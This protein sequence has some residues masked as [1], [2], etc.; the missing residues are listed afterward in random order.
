LVH[1]NESVVN[2]HKRLYAVDRS[3][4]GQWAKRVKASGSADSELRD[5]VR[6]G[7]P[8]FWDC[9]GVILVDVMPR[10]V[11]INSEAYI[12]KLEKRFRLVWPGKNPAEMLLQHDN[13]HPHTGL[14]TREHITKMGWTMLPHP[15]YSPDLAP[16]DFHVFGSLRDALR[17]THF[18]D[19]NSVIEAMSG[20]GKEYMR[21]FHAV[22]RP[23][24][25]IYLF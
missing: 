24:K 15:P 19:D 4:V 8:A 7:C 10:G 1:E 17:G 13:A 12:N 2:I 20:T 5:L 22:V 16:S 9:D 23:Y 14:R 3:S 11:T 18:E 21:L 25:F 6:A